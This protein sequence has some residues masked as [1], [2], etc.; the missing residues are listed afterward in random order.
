MSLRAYLT[1][2]VVWCTMVTKEKDMTYDYEYDRMVNDSD[3]LYDLYTESVD[4][5]SDNYDDGYDYTQEY[6]NYY[7]NVADEIADDDN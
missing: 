7:F 1:V 6:D 2:V 5:D 3:D 4:E